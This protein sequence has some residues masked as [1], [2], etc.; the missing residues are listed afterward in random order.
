MHL[1]VALAGAVLGR[2][3]RGN[4]RGIDHR[5]DLEQQALVDQRGVDRR[6]YLDA[7]LVFFEQVTWTWGFA[8]SQNADTVWN[9][10][11]TRETNEFVGPD[12]FVS[13]G[14]QARR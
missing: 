12:L 10:L 2:T 1:R 13:S 9:A 4:Q 11:G 3:G 5:T 8:K 7:E 14:Q 6:Q